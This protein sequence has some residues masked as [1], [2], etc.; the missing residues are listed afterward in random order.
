MVG[1]GGGLDAEVGVVCDGDDFCAEE[2]LDFG[3]GALTFE[4]GENVVGGA[5]AE[6]LAECFFVV[7]DAVLFYEGDEVGGGV[8]AEGR[9]GEVGVFGEEVFGAG[10]EVGEVAAA[11]SGDE[12][13]FA[14][15]IGVVD[16]EDS[17]VAAA[18]FDGA[19]ESGCTC[20]QD[21][22]V[23]LIVV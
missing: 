13:F 10:V 4:H 21:D 19:E 23:V 12:D 7:G 20:S 5:V 9:F 15:L 1:A 18:G 17:E 11:S 8:A 22:C 2:G 14:G 3:L 16:V 6:E